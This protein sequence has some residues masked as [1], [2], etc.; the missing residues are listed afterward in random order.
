MAELLSVFTLAV[1]FA[2][3][4]IMLRF[5]GKT[6]LFVYSTVAIIAS[7][8]QVLKLTKY[9][10]VD[11][12]IALGT[13]LF[14]T[15][16]AVDNILTEHYGA[17]TARRC[18]WAG[19]V[20]YLFFA[21]VM[22]IAVWHPPVVH[23]ECINLSSELRSIFSPC[24]VF[25]IAGLAACVTGQLVDIALFSALKKLTAGK[26]VSFRSFLSTSIAAFADNFIFSVLAWVIL[27]D[28]PISMSSL[29][30]TYIFTTYIL[31]LAVA[32]ACVP[33]VRWSGAAVP[34]KIHV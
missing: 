10:C 22:K 3:I 20:S 14:S 6:G 26:Y 16:F 29:R 21:T 11:S 9:S 27:A 34:E 15:I 28:N 8:M 1:C 18:V 7:N 30:D 23:G 5:F 24:F 31:R 32:A 25:L 19:F 2:A 13:V 17:E 33:L 12:P 4:L